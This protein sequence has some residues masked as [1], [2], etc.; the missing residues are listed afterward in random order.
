MS[1]FDT[2]VPNPEPVAIT[3]KFLE[4]LV[5]DGKKFVDQEALAK[6]KYEADLHVANL[7]R[8]LAEMRKDIDQGS[9]ITELMELV[10]ENQAKPVEPTTPPTEGPGDTS[11]GQMSEE[12]LKALIENHVSSR[13]KDIT[14]TKNIQEADKLLRGKFGDAAQRVLHD[15]AASMDM[16]VE[17]MQALAGIN[18]KAFNRLMGLDGDT[19]PEPT[20]LGG[21]Q[22]T[23]SGE[24]RGANT[25][26]FAFYQEMRR[27]NKH[28]YYKPAIQTQMVKDAEEQG[29]AFYSNS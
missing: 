20:M 6:G 12:E 19:T 21:G 26:D 25:R 27:K 4:N 3:E 18:P 17:E 29:K 16:A 24:Q 9:K 22:R 7:E 14:S 11:T 5:G 8:Q 28:A 13:D 23:E 15:R 1:A 2:N 10:R